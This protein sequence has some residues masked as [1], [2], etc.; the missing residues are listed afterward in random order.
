MYTRPENLWDSKVQRIAFLTLAIDGEW[1]SS[2]P[3]HLN[4]EKNPSVAIA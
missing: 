4:P 3:G 1:S 2:F